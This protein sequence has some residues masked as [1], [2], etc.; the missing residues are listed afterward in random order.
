[1]PLKNGRQTG[2]ESV[3]IQHYAATGDRRYAALQA[4]SRDPS[5]FA[6]KALAR[7]AVQAEIARIQ[8]ERLY[9]EGL[10]L[11]VDMHIHMIRDPATPAGARA[12]AIKLMYDRTIGQGDQ[13][14]A[15]EPHE[16]TAEELEAAIQKLR[17]A[18][19]D[20]AKPVLEHDP[21]PGV[22]K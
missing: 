9:T 15:K 14:E 16:M 2:Q 19:A 1:M 4:G 21:A 18:A 6:A 10:A 3:F 12:Q 7:P 8:V 20:K 11:A 5:S 22:F 17:R 13:A